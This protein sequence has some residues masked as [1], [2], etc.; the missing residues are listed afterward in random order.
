MRGPRRFLSKRGWWPLPSAHPQRGRLKQHESFAIGPPLLT[1][2]LGMTAF[3]ELE[4]MSRR[5]ATVSP[6]TQFLFR[7]YIRIVFPRPRRPNKPPTTRRLGVDEM[8]SG[9]SVCGYAFYPEEL[10]GSLWGR[11][12]GAEPAH[13]GS[14]GENTQRGDSRLRE[15]ARQEAETRPRRALHRV[16][17]P[18]FS[19]GSVRTSQQKTCRSPT[20]KELSFRTFSNH[21]AGDAV[22]SGW[23]PLQSP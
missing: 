18:A 21:L 6:E 23:L 5:P 2:T 4:V 19:A 11:R 13:R 10:Q 17:R 1:H 9:V 7:S 14:R 16:P 8:G 22:T 20:E 3:R 12:A 15:R